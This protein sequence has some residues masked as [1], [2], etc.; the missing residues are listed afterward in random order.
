MKQRT[1]VLPTRRL[2]RSGPQITEV[3]L[4]AWAMGGGGWA[5]SWGPQDDAASVRTIRHAV[6]SGVNWI[7]TAAV[8]GHG[9]SEQVVGRALHEMASADRPYVFTKGGL[10]WSD[11]EPM[12]D[13]VNDLRPDTIRKEV[14]GSLKRLG[15]DVIDLYQFHWPDP[16]T[17]VEESWGTLAELVTAGKVRWAGVSNFDVGLLGRCERIRHVDSVQPPFSI[18]NRQSAADVIPWAAAHGTG[19]IVYSPMQ[20]GLLTGKWSRAHKLAPDDWRRHDEEFVEPRLS[21]NLALAEALEPVA[22]RHHASVAEIAVAWTLAW[23]G[24]T[25]AIVGGRSPE[26]VDGWVHAPRHRL[27][28]GDLRRIARG[29]EETQAGDGPL[30][31][32]QA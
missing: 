12:R 9:H 22:E 30:A 20:S 1:V 27:D 10:R 16:S 26:Q 6:E 19:V 21:R 11:E 31:P 25:G 32:P 13:A 7:D 4:G 24:V 17:P 2:G 28:A 3:G 8:Y 5:F 29:I 23:R 14:D 18:I 15:A